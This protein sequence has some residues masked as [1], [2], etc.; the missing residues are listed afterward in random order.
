MLKH[1]KG[2]CEDS[3]LKHCKGR[4]EGFNDESTLREDARIQR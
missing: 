2:R 4:C 1:C 3:M